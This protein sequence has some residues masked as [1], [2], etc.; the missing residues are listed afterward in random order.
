LITEKRICYAAGGVANKAAS[1]GSI[2]QASIQSINV[3]SNHM[4]E[5]QLPAHKF[6]RISQH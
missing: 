4:T 5:G 1:P 6:A 2:P 3:I